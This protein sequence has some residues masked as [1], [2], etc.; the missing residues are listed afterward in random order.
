MNINELEKNELLLTE[1]IKQ[2]LPALEIKKVQK[3]TG[4]SGRK[5]DLFFIGKLKYKEYKFICEI[6]N[7]ASPSH[8]FPVIMMLKQAA[9]ETKSY[10]IIIAPYV[11]QRSAEICRKSGVGFIDSG[12]NVFLSFDNILIDRRVKDRVSL[13]KKEIAEIFSPRAT[14][15]IRVLLE[16]KKEKWLITELA[17]E[18]NLSIGYTSEV[19][20]ALIKQGYVDRQKRKGFYLKEKSALL[21][22][23][24][25]VYN[26]SK[27]RIIKFYTFEKNFS[28]LFAKINTV[29]DLIKSKCALT[30]LSAA[31]TVAPYIARF[32]D[33]YLYVEGNVEQWKEKLDLREVEAGANFYLIVPY[34]EG[35]FYALRQVKGALVVGNI[36]LYLDLIKYPARGKEQAEYLRTQLIKF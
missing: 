33:I 25:S 22:R 19:L 12:G 10:P 11:S 17:K 1:K 8:L 18:A 16:G 14:R 21:D 29:A 24:A 3:E 20:N 5:F 31:S 28:S 32:S 36:Q 27:N 34:D 2:I 23:W 6:K 35:V 15:V 26:F 9:E 13:E 4:L 30:L 7:S